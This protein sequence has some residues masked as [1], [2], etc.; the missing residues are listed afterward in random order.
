MLEERVS[1]AFF[2]GQKLFL[3]TSITFALIIS[4][5]Y[6]LK[7]AAI[8]LM[9]TLYGIQI[10]SCNFIIRAIVKIFEIIL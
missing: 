1:V 7:Q 9:K 4:L 10:V 5:Q 6:D 3:E 2:L 8:F